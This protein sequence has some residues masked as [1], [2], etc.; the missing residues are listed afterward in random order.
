MQLILYII[1]DNKQPI[2][3]EEFDIELDEELKD[4]LKI[5][6]YEGISYISSLKELAKK[7]NKYACAELGSLEFSGLVSGL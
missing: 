2:Y 4:Y 7:D 5:N 6:L 1:L 3:I